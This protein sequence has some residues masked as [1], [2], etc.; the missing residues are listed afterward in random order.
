MID[1]SSLTLL[2]GKKA[3]V[4]GIANDQSIAWG[5]AKAFRA[6]GRR[7]CDHLPQ[8][9]DAS[10]YVEPL[11]E[12]STRR[13]FCRSTCATTASSRPSS[14][15]IAKNGAR[16][17]LC[18]IRSRSRRRRICRAA[19]STARK[20]GF[21]PG[22]GPLLLV[23]HPHGQA[24]RAADEDGRR[25][26]HDDLLRLADGRRKL[27][28]DGAGEGRPR[29]GDALHGRRAWSQG[30]PGARHIARAAQDPRGFRHRRVRRAAAARR[31]TRHRR[32]VSSPS[33]TSASP[34][35]SSPPMP[36]S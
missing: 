12:S 4:T 20:E 23:V 28:H 30:H 14:T 27:Q 34:S 32:A 2:K 24:R 36:P 31:R 6:L 15:S 22:H 3:L 1:L 7:P 8:R 17:I 16:S 13:S 11:A 29:V 9:Q 19:S 21:L 5:C 10:T 35:P 33:T 26:V 25:A 18:C